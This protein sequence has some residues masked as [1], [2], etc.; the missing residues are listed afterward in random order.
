MNTVRELHIKNMVC[1]RC[2]AAVEESLRA[3]DLSF[4]EVRLGQVRLSAPQRLDSP[5]MRAF[6]HGI[7]EKGFEYLPQT[8]KQ[9][10]NRIKPLVLEYLKLLEE[11]YDDGSGGPTKAPDRLSSFLSGRLF[12]NYSYLSER[13]SREQ[14]K[15][16]EQFFIELRIERAK[17]LL[18]Q[19]EQSI[20]EIARRLGF[21]SSQHLAG[22]F[23]TRTGRTPSAWRKQ[24]GE[25]QRLDQL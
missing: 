4:D 24:P 2:V 1:P 22:Q 3:Q 19:R 13:F 15:S 20:S 21:S 17:A 7:Q 6:F 8:E 10:S 5:A 12:K 16:I 18:E 9:L 25:R 14:G 11:R 23:K